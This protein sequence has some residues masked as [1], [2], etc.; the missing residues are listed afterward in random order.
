MTEEKQGRYEFTEKLKEEFIK[1]RDNIVGNVQ[2][3]GLA[4]NN[5]SSELVHAKLEE[6]GK[7]LG[8]DF[9][10]GDWDFDPEGFAFFRAEKKEKPKSKKKPAVPSTEV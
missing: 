3:I 10:D 1:Y 9:T 4:V 8:V 2:S 6:I 7:V 5:L